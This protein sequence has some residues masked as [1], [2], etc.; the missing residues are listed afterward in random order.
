MVTVE[1]AA[2]LYEERT[3]SM[4]PKCI[5]EAMGSAF[6]SVASFIADKE[7]TSAGNPLA[8]YVTFD[9]D[10]MPFRAGFVVSEEDARKAK[11]DVKCDVLP[12]GDVLNFVHRG[13]YAML[14]DSYVAMMK[15]LE[16]KGMSVG[17]PS[18]EIYLNDPSTVASE[19]DLE[20]DVYV[21]VA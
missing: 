12:D 2:Y 20:T 19:A 8:V 6:Q 1:P 15:H 21:T 9:P 4:D 16:V 18:W 13:P 7:I 5:S 10:K 11:G 3:C 14:R 17:M